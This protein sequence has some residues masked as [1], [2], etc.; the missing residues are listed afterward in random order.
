MS[1]NTKNP[2]QDNLDYQQALEV[3]RDVSVET[4]TKLGQE[5]VAGAEEVTEFAGV[6]GP[7]RVFSQAKDIA[8]VAG[9]VAPED[10]LEVADIITKSHAAEV[11]AV[12][13]A[14]KRSEELAETP[15]ADAATTLLKEHTA[16]EKQASRDLT[17]EPQ[18]IDDPDAHAYQR[19]V[20]RK[21]Y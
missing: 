14:L 2:S 4:A 20:Q 15:V 5:A 17:R 16:F 12:G 11:V 6:T 19:A 18:D 9:V 8:Y 3:I 7:Q 10:T 1:E 21:F 13:E